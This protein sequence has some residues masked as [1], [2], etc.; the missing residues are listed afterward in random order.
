MSVNV[1]LLGRA[2]R[3]VESQQRLASKAWY[4]GA[5]WRRDV[6][7][8]RADRDD[9]FCGSAMCVAGKVCLDAGFLPVIVTE[10]DLPD[11]EWADQCQDP[12][13]GEILDF[14]VAAARLLG[15]EMDDARLL[16]AGSNNVNDIRQI[17]E[18]IAGQPL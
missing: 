3:W 5:W 9:P 17:A 8:A 11:V 14:D 7:D 4:Q 10:S 2:V 6:A 1:R 18:D 15:I 13:T 16:F 12:I